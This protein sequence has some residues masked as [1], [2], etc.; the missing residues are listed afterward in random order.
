MKTNEIFE[1][2]FVNAFILEYYEIKKYELADKERLIFALCSTEI[3]RIEVTKELIK[4]LKSEIQ[5]LGF[6]E[7]SFSYLMSGK[8]H[9]PEFIEDY[10]QRKEKYIQL[11]VNSLEDSI[12][13][14]FPALYFDGN[15]S[16]ER[17]DSDELLF[18]DYFPSD[19]EH[20]FEHFKEIEIILKEEITLI[21]E[22]FKSSKDWN[23]DFD[24]LEQLSLLSKPLE[25]LFCLSELFIKIETL[26]N[27]QS[28]L[29]TYSSNE[30]P[31]DKL[32]TPVINPFKDKQ[33]AELIEYIVNNWNYHKQQKWANIS[34][35]INSLNKG[36]IPYPGDYETY[37]RIK[38]R[39]TGK[40]QYDKYVNDN[41]HL[42]D[43]LE[44]IKN[45]SKK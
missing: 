21:I 16:D 17:Y 20:N 22:N 18:S 44:L 5:S 39:Y 15:D 29:N 11:S 7:L 1:S 14:F 12:I 38:Y 30:K 8:N 36:A 43:L 13:S 19:I 37:I 40:F 23:F 34:V 45:F 6:E 28:F 33:T 4:K 3:E 27:Y 2:G 9:H 35:A 24:Y 26:E 32:N 10:N 42:N 41:R 31:I 25:I